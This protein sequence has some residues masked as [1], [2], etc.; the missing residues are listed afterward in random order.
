MERWQVIA[1]GHVQGVG[2]RVS[3]RDYAQNL[4]LT[5]YVQNLES[6]QVRLEVQGLEEHLQLF[7]AQ[8]K[9]IPPGSQA[10]L[11]LVQMA[12]QEGEAGFVINQ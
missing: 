5:G 11:Q 9:L 8:I 6:G 4:G 2:F 10:S 7:F 1:S 12:V 3:A